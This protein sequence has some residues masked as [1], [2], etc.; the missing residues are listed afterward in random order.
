[1]SPRGR[2]VAPGD[3][4]HP[5][6]AAWCLLGSFV[7]LGVTIGVLVADWGWSW[8]TTVL[9]ALAVALGVLTA[10][11]LIPDTDDDPERPAE[12]PGTWPTL[13]GG[14]PMERVPAD[15]DAR[16]FGCGSVECDGR[17]TR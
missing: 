5:I 12:Y 7:L 16:C 10:V 2:R 1:M 3:A 4:A 14:I 13:S 15:L 11:C 6:A 17:C 8:L 9:G